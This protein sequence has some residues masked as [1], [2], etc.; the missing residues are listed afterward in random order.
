MDVLMLR[1]QGRL[2]AVSAHMDVLMLRGQG[3]LRAVS[4]HMDVLMLRGQG[5]LRAVF[6]SNLNQKASLVQLCNLQEYHPSEFSNKSLVIL[7]MSE[8]EYS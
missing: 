3:R 2:R 4:A 7:W 1:G 8:R 5:R 6:V